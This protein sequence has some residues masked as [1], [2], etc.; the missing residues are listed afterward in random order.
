MISIFLSLSI[1]S[2]MVASSPMLHGWDTVSDMLYAHGSAD[3]I[4]ES[5]AIDFLA[6]NYQMVT[7]G[8][9]YGKSNGTQEKAVE[10]SA[11]AIK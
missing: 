4:L 11:A 10:Q 7:F 8:N 9:C 3:S 5:D 1:V 6:S 2:Q